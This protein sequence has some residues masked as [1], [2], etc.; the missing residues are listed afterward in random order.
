SGISNQKSPLRDDGAAA[1]IVR[2]SQ[3]EIASTDLRD[4]AAKATPMNYA[5]EDGAQVIATYDQTLRGIG[6]DPENYLSGAFDRANGNLGNSTVMV[7]NVKPAITV[8]DPL[9]PKNLYLR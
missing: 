1:V 4:R 9:I 5:I 3:S 2:V 6:I 7:P 8:I